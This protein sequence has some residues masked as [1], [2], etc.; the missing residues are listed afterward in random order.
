MAPHSLHENVLPIA[1]L[2]PK[3]KSGPKLTR[4]ISKEYN[5]MLK[6]HIGNCKFET[7]QQSCI[8]SHLKRKNTIQQLFHAY[9]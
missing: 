6:C 9:I 2:V 1:L 5:G 8:E 4:N 3:L 7:N